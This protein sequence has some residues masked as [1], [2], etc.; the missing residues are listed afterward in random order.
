MENKIYIK[1]IKNRGRLFAFLI[2]VCLLI[3][4]L[5]AC[6]P[7]KAKEVLT[8]KTAMEITSE[9]GIGWNLGN[10]FDATGGNKSNVYS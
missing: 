3:Q 4:I 2:C 6:S 7:A 8:G 5:P 1:I 10:T 9:M